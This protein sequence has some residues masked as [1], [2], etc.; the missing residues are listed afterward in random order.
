VSHQRDSQR[1]TGR[2]ARRPTCLN[3]LAATTPA[4]S[5][6]RSAAQRLRPREPH[7]LC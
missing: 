4:G 3:R 7:E 1:S 6:K 5:T 2:S